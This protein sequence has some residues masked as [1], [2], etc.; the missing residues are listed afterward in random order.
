MS[1]PSIII[2]ASHSF[3]DPLFQGLMFQYILNLQQIHSN[4]YS[5]HL[6]TEEQ[7]NYQCSI[8]E[9]RDIKIQLAEKNIHW[10]PQPYRGGRFIL[11]KKLWHFIILFHTLRTIKRNENVKLIIG[12]LAIASGYSYIISRLLKTKFMVFCFEPHSLYMKEFGIWS[13]HSLKYKLLHRIEKLQATRS[14]YVVGPT[15]HTIELLEKWKSKSK[16]F[17]VPISVDTEKFSFSPNKRQSIRSLLKIAEDRYVMMYLGKFGGIYYNEEQVAQ[18]CRRLL[19]FDAAIYFLIISP[20]DPI[21]IKITF[22][23]QGISKPDFS[24]LNTIPYDEIENYISASDMGIVAI[25]PLHSQKFRTPVK[26]GN[27][28]SCGLPFIINRGIA[29]DDIMAEEENVGVVFE[30]LEDENID[31]PLK[32]LKALMSEDRKIQRDRCRKAAIKH[33]GIHNSTSVLDQVIRACYEN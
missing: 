22:E 21:Q 31:V 9:Q 32:K 2:C 7:K 12:F 8:D 28:L 10:H 13:E 19:Q 27:Y 16:L 6:I 5:Y 14:D 30:S 17:R 3:K 26:V 1:K 25:P 20:N 18:F 33:R 15:Y 23:K 24:V 29:D 11:L 4:S